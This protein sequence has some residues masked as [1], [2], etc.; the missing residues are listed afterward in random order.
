MKNTI[1]DKLQ[2]RKSLKETQSNM[3][4]NRIHLI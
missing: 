1:N 2:T 4:I 3:K